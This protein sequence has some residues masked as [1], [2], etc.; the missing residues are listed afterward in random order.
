MTPDQQTTVLCF[1]GGL[2]SSVLLTHLQ[3]LGHTVHALNISYGSLHNT[4]ERQRAA[5][6]AKNAGVLYQ[7]IDLNFVDKLYKSALLKSGPELPVGHYSDASMRQTVV[8]GRNTIF[9][10]I[11]IGY[12][13]SIGAQNIA[14]ANHADDHAMYPDTTPEWIA[15]MQ[16][17]AFHGTYQRVKVIAPFTH[18]S[19]AM[20][21]KRGKELGLAFD[22]TWTCYQGGEVHCGRC[23]SC[24]SRK[25]A[26]AKAG[27][28]DPTTYLE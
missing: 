27:I 1:S 15:A 22:Q 14:I 23:G 16:L 6:F 26:F 18:W 28:E 10:S 13:E 19:K 21:C 12:A 25:E 8:P 17:A 24:S 11:A 2:D 20:I 5:A 7:E 3:D 4:A 9:L